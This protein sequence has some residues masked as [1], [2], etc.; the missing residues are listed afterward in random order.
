MKLPF[1]RPLHSA[2]EV[3]EHKA[4]RLAEDVARKLEG[5][6]EPR[7]PKLNDTTNKGI[8]DNRIQEIDLTTD[9]GWGDPKA[10]WLSNH[11]VHNAVAAIDSHADNWSINT[12]RGG[13][14]GWNNLTEPAAKMIKGL[15]TRIDPAIHVANAEFDP[16][17]ELGRMYDHIEALHLD[18]IDSIRKR[19][20]EIR[21][22]ASK[23]ARSKIRQGEIKELQG[24]IDSMASATHTWAINFSEARKEVGY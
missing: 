17:G 19:G 11:H 13:P 22:G 4:L 10:I 7:S 8:A 24:V 18:K 5:L 6:P 16:Q 21:K 20:D 12:M 23:A 3:A 9:L 14:G 15:R 2:E 1:R